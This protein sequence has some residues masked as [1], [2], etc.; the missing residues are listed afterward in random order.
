MRDGKRKL[1]WRRG[2][3]LSSLRVEKEEAK[4]ESSL[5]CHEI[6]SVDLW[7]KKKPRWPYNAKPARPRHPVF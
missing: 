5:L 3:R 6:Y 2:N 4:L 7:Y 1:L